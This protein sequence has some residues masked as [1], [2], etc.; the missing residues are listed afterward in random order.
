MPYNESFKKYR[1]VF[2]S[3]FGPGSVQMFGPSHEFASIKLLKHLLDDPDNFSDH[4][5]LCV[6]SFQLLL[7][8]LTTFLKDSWLK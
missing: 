2:T 7:H 3:K 5:R 4:V 8:D 6:V 1:R